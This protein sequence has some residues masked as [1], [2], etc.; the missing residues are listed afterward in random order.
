MNNPYML[1]LLE[2]YGYIIK[3]FPHPKIQPFLK[4]FYFQERVEPCTYDSCR[5]QDMLLEA[6]LLITD[7]SSIAFDFAYLEKGG[8]ILP[9]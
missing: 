7:Y 5:V 3:F 9:I 2:A 8:D 1:E 4:G 6:S